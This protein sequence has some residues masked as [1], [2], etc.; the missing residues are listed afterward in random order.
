MGRNF[1]GERTFAYGTCSGWKSTVSCVEVKNKVS[2][3]IRNNRMSRINETS[4]CYGN[5][6]RNNDLRSSQIYFILI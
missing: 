5:I 6:R 1:K 4:G 2:Q 3:R